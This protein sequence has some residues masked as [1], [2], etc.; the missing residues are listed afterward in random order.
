MVTSRFESVFCSAVKTAI[1]ATCGARTWAGI[2]I[3]ILGVHGTSMAAS[4]R[5][6]V[7]RPPW[8]PS[9]SRMRGKSLSTESASVSKPIT[10]RSGGLAAA[11]EAQNEVT[12]R[13]VIGDAVDDPLNHRDLFGVDSMTSVRQLLEARVHLGHKIGTWDPRMKP[14]LFGSRAGVHIIDLDKTLSHLRRALNVAGHVALRNG[15][16]LFVSERSQFERLVQKC[17]RDCC[18]YLVTQQWV[19][20]TLTNSQML[21]G[22]VRLPD[23]MI[24]LSVPPSK[25]AIK[26]AAMCNVPSIGVVDSDCNPNLITYPIPGNDDTSA[27]VSLYCSLFSEVIS[28]A[29]AT[30]ERREKGQYKEGGKEQGEKDELA[31]EH[32]IGSQ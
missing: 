18:E 22:T 29:K 10:L 9:W 15:I 14:Y 2:L 3:R 26:E 31:S 12:D 1:H 28:R 24:F 20:G 25:T 17:A 11:P 23:L 16:I 21:L 30:R 27:A 4:L 5:R 19:G 32:T 6:I 13:A 7:S 8:R